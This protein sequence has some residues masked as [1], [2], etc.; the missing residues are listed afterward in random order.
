[1]QVKVRPAPGGRSLGAKS[2]WRLVPSPALP[3]YAHSNQD[4]GGPVGTPGEDFAPSRVDRPTALASGLRRRQVSRMNAIRFQRVREALGDLEELAEYRALWDDPSQK[5]QRFRQG[6]ERL[7]VR[8]MELEPNAPTDREVE[9]HLLQ[10]EG[11]CVGGLARYRHY[12]LIAREAL[13]S[14]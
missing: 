11:L 4:V 9:D 7:G 8:C 1:M 6:V 13:H 12:I 3:R 10:L 5:A 14:K 2:L